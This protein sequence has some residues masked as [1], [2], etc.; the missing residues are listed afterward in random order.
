MRN[1]AAPVLSLV[2]LA[3]S[4][5]SGSASGQGAVTPI[6][7]SNTARAAVGMDAPIEE[8]VAGFNDAGFDVLRDQPL[9]ENNVL[10]PVSISHALLMARGAAD[11]PTGAAIDS[12]L[13]LPEGM[14]AHEAWNA[15]DQM[16]AAAND[17]AI[18]LDGEPS[19][20]ITIADRIWPDSTVTPDQ[21]WVDLLATHHGSD[22]ATI[23]VD[24][25]DAS[26]D[27]INRW[28][29]EATEGLIPEL[30]PVG[31]IKPT[32][33]LVLTDAI[34][35]KAQ[36]QT[37]FGKYGPVDG[38]FVRLDGT[39]LDIEFMRDL[40]NR[41]ARGIGDGWV[42]ADLPYL[43]EDFSMLVI[44]PDEGEFEAVRASLG[45]E[46][47]AEIDAVIEP[48]P[49]E[50]LLP[51]WEDDSNIDLLPWLTEIGAAPGSY[52]KI[53]PGS[54]LSGGV[55]AADIAVDEMGTV[56]AAA[57]GLGFDESG[58]PEPEITIAADKPFLYVIRHNDSGLALFAGQVTDPTR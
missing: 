10:S 57:T 48:G 42:A 53:T 41:G 19:P 30:L 28:V 13:G 9:P 47:L 22:V 39:G 14:A 25:P 40:E 33:T 1:F 7:A 56:A 36:W 20:V 50:L 6:Q 11:G 46:F 52:P 54:F 44:V 51:R 3:A 43:G 31:F 21:E 18:A 27:E 15:V 29:S 17:S 32:T 12:A 38:E 23:D 2:L 5:G 58:P 4:C 24:Q 26:R 16:I 55:H 49:F 34:Y 37:V 8:L 45:Q 35:F